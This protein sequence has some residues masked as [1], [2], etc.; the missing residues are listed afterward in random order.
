AAA[1]IWK[2][3]VALPLLETE[4]GISL[5]TA[6]MLV[7]IIQLASMVGGLLVA[8]GGEIAGLRRL[9]MIGLLLLA[10]GS[11]LG[12]TTSSANLMMVFRGIEGIGFLLCTVL[13][14]ALIRRICRPEQLNLALSSWGAFQ[15]TATVLG[16][17]GGG[18]LLEFVS[19]RVLWVIMTAITLIL[20]V[21]VA[22][23]TDMDP[24]AGGDNRLKE[25]L[26]RIAHT[27]RT[28]RPWVAGLAFASYTLQ[29]MAVIGFL[30]TVFVA[31][32]VERLSAALLSS[33]V[34]GVNIIGALMVATLL[35]RG[36]RPRYIL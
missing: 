34:G 5:V 20:L 11:C 29:W 7:G 12:A 13:A 27:V 31:A 10:A 1:H 26:T 30:P 32:N 8:W 17:A 23:F 25:S 3:P 6:G 21:L 35:G 22:R 28:E 9:I 24:P 18:V 36:F 4:L 16:F 19:W 14:P 33:V 2:L 15:G